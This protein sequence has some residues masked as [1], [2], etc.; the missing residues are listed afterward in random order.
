MNELELNLIERISADGDVEAN[1]NS[2]SISISDDGK[3]IPFESAATN[4]FAFADDLNNA[5]DIF[6]YDRSAVASILNLDGSPPPE[7][8]TVELVSVAIDD[9]ESANGSSSS[10]VISG[11]GQ[12]VSFN[13]S[14]SNLVTDDDNNFQDV[15]LRDLANNTTE[16]ISVSNDGTLANGISLFSAISA[17]GD[18][19]AFESLA[20]NLVT[21]D[22]NG[23]PDIFLRD[24]ANE[25]TKLVTTSIDSSGADSSSVLGS[26]SD[27]CQ[28]P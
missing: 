18:Y 27:D 7:L 10:A 22:T 1:G 13:S 25:T 4:L 5:T 9:D 26:I 21:D 2:G 3:V 17:D 8:P 16:V 19:V 12:Y 24:R 20:S 28:I 11:N 15:F 6:V 23:L 14:A